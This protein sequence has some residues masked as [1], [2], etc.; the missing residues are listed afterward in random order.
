L[1]YALLAPLSWRQGGGSVQFPGLSGA[2]KLL[3]KEHL[4]IRDSPPLF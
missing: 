4:R 3:A 2:V 1:E